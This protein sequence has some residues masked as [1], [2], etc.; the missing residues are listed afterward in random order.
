L[1]VAADGSDYR[2][3]KLLRDYARTG[4]PQMSDTT[5]PEIPQKARLL[6]KLREGHFNVPEFVYVPAA[7][8]QR[9][10]FK[11]LKDF[12]GAERESFK[13]IARSAH[14]QEEFFK[15]GTF[16][17]LETYA[18]VEGIKYARRRMITIAGT[19][20]RL[21][22]LRQQTFNGA[23]EID[24]GQMGVVV[25]PFIAGMSV[26]AKKVGERWEFGYIR[27]TGQKV[28][29]EPYI[30][31]TPH[32]RKLLEISSDIQRCL[33]FRCEIEYVISEDGE[34]HVVQA[35][36]ISHIETLELKESERSLKLDGVRRVRKRR[37][38]RERPIYVMDSRSFYLDI[39]SK[40]EDVVLEG[41]AREPGI[42]DI[43]DIIASYEAD[44]ESFALRQE[45]YGIL[46]LSIKVPQDLYQIANHYLDEFP[47]LQKRISAALYNNLYKRDYFLSEADTLIAKDR[48]RIHLR[49]HDAYGIDTVRNPMWS[50]YWHMQRH[51]EVAKEFRRLGFKTGDTIGIDIDSEEKPT[52]FR[53]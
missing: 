3:A 12:L 25:M 44:L 22:I 51:D 17:S 18:D 5:N 40:C 43:L 46:G 41:E 24:L 10:N 19:A 37:N 32:D 27:D 53:L 35:K 28:E 39:I 4:E 23:P 8:F 31:Q 42:E 34:I 33:G 20:K 49:S 36:D 29:S 38:Y 15:G 45:L 21:T 11:A 14:P 6:E 48:V 1:K 9:E 13:V 30:T 26:M 50:V 7:D 47:P 52:V 2:E 16:D